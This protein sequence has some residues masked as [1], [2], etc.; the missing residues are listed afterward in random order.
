MSEKHKKVCAALSYIEQSFILVS[1][2]T[3][4]VSISDFSSLVGIPI[5]VASYAVALRMYTITAEIKKYESI[6][7]KKRKKSIIK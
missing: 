5:G 3:G 1:A 7:N 2:I 4:C 6:I